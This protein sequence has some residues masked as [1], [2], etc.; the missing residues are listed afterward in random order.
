MKHSHN[1]VFSVHLA[2]HISNSFS[3]Y[4]TWSHERLGKGEGAKKCQKLKETGYEADTRT[5]QHRIINS[6]RA[7]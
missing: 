3:P 1:I 6:K 2:E 7:R 4:S 5:T